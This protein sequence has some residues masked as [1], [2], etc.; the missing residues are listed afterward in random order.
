MNKVFVGIALL[1]IT[2]QSEAHLTGFVDVDASGATVITFDNAK[3]QIIIPRGYGLKMIN[4]PSDALVRECD[5]YFYSKSDI[6]DD[7]GRAL[8]LE[9]LYG[10]ARYYNTSWSQ[11]LKLMWEGFKIGSQIEFAVL[12]RLFIL[13]RPIL[14]FALP[15]WMQKNLLKFRTQLKLGEATIS[16]FFGLETD[17]IKK[18]IHI[19]TSVLQNDI[20]ALM[21]SWITVLNLA[22]S[23]S[24]IKTLTIPLLGQEKYTVGVIS[25]RQRAQIGM[26]ALISFIEEHPSRFDS[27]TL[28]TTKM[29]QEICI[30]ELKKMLCH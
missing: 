1:C 14:I 4:F 9:K 16:D 24:S 15:D 17:N 30:N 20:T 19:N 21:Q 12:Y 11:K 18:L 27:I 7:L 10:W 5:E 25:F 6:S 28:I 26:A 13:R 2:F 23:H 29:N 22:A 8:D 3:T